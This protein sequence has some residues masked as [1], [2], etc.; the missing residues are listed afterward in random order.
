MLETDGVQF[1]GAVMVF[2]V[3]IELCKFCKALSL[4]LSISKSVPSLRIPM[5]G[6][7]PK[8]EVCSHLSLYEN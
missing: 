2:S 1:T 7:I 6:Y 8:F 4:M 3:K 5:S